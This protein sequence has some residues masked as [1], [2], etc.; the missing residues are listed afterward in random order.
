MFRASRLAAVA[1]V[2]AAALTLSACGGAQNTGSRAPAKA[3]EK[4]SIATAGYLTIMAPLWAAQPEFDKVAQ[5]F[6]TEI[7]FQQFGKA[8]DAQTALL[9]GGVQVNTATSAGV[10]LQAALQ[11]QAVVS[12]ANMFTGGGIVLVGAKKYEAERGTNVAKYAGATWGYA[13][14]GSGSQRGSKAIVEH[15]GLSW[16][17]Q[18]G[19]ALGAIAAFEPAL[20]SGRADIVAMDPTSAAKAL[21]SGTGYVVFNSNDLDAY[22]P[23]VGP[24]LGNTVA[25]TDDFRKQY[26]ELTQAVVTAYVQGLLKVRDAADVNAFYALMPPEFQQAHPN[27]AL[28]AEDWAL[29]KPAFLAADGSFSAE[30]IAATT[31]FAELTPEQAQSPLVT[32][33]F[34]DSY[35]EAAYKELG[36]PRPTI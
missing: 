7:S 14:E 17:D 1:A 21:T 28:L 6:G 24:L 5:E 35:V 33:T 13:S 36:V 11:D 23:V 31:K 20:Q 4:V 29:S 32:A 30:A 8:T 9:S 34:D 27:D 3:P 10:S 22:G 18:K 19:V 26:P 16:A 2:A 25:V 12:T 15:A